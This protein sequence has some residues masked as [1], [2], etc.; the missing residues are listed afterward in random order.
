MDAHNCLANQENQ[1]LKHQ[2]E[3][4]RDCLERVQVEESQAR[5]GPVQWKAQ[6]EAH[7][8]EA[9]RRGTSTEESDVHARLASITEGVRD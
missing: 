4:T 3:E 7:L 9:A 2:L 1:S 5:L 6:I 8:E